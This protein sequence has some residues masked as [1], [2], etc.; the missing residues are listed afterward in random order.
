MIPVASIFLFFLTSC[1]LFYYDDHAYCETTDNSYETSNYSEK[2]FYVDEVI[3]GDTFS[4]TSGETVRML[5]INT[6]EID[7]YYYDEARDMLDIMICGKQVILERDITERDRYGRLLRYVYTDD[8]FINL[9]MVRRGYANVYTLPPDIRYVEDLLEAERSAR[10]N[11]FGLWAQ[12]GDIYNIGLFLNHDAEGDDRENLNG[13]YLIL[14]NEGSCDYNIRGWTVKDSGTNIY[15]FKRFMFIED[16]E[17]TL[18][19][20]SG[21]NGDGIFYWNS[22]VPVWNNDH[23][24]AYLRDSKG[25][26][27]KYFEY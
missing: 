24:S 12:S 7:R 27:I 10:K 16:S 14:R 21:K 3:D 5:G 26:L 22:P 13:E 1:G 23:D 25:F 20:G 17:V 19:T 6:P 2:I 15:E 9:E 8:L 4:T 18:F 11:E